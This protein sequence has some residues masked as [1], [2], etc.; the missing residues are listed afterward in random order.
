MVYLYV[1]AGLIGTM[2][3]FSWFRR[4]TSGQF[5]IAVNLLLAVSGLG[6]LL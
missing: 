2:I 1:P 4:M 6:L 3:G 5:N